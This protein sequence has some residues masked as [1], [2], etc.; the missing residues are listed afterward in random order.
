MKARRTP[1]V[2]SKSALKAKAEEVEESLRERSTYTK[3]RRKFA[4]EHDDLLMK[5]LDGP[6][7]FDPLTGQ[8]T[9]VVGPTAV[10]RNIG[11]FRFSWG[12]RLT[13]HQHLQLYIGFAQEV[14]NEPSLGTWE[15]DVWDLKNPR[16]KVPAINNEAN[17]NEFG[18]DRVCEGP[19]RWTALIEKVGKAADDVESIKDYFDWVQKEYDWDTNIRCYRKLLDDMRMLI[20]MAYPQCFEDPPSWDALDVAME[21]HSAIAEKVPKDVLQATTHKGSNAT[22]QRCVKDL[23]PVTKSR[24]TGPQAFD[25]FNQDFKKV[26][27]GYR[28]PQPPYFPEVNTWIALREWVSEMSTLAMDKILFP[29]VKEEFLPVDPNDSVDQRNGG[30]D[31]E[32]HAS[33]S[34]PLP[35]VGNRNDLDIFLEPNYM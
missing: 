21:W 12:K 11:L 1:S 28:E 32:V 13:R 26:F 19:N 34:A 17:L 5:Q 35:T 20:F 7:P 6:F 24:L 15:Q 22:W 4:N 14:E 9:N 18:R 27:P 33:C 2:P 29:A 23:H 10:T 31:P 30:G 16:I 3:Q 8:L 25:S